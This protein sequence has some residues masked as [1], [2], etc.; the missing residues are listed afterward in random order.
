MQQS[1]MA[2]LAAGATLVT[3]TPSTP[4]NAERR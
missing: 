2:A 4:G 1:V 3:A